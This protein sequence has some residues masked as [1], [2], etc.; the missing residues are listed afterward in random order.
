M[1]TTN[2]KGLTLVE[3]LVAVVLTILAAA[4]IYRGYVSIVSS[5]EVQEQ[6]IELQQ[7]L[8]VAMQTMVKEMRLA[9][10]DPTRK[11]G[12]SILNT[13]SAVNFD[14]TMDM[15]GNK[16]VD[17]TVNYRLNG[18]DLERQENGAGYE[19]IISNVEVLNFVYLNAN[20]A[21]L[22]LPLGNP[23]LVRTVQVAIVARTTNEDYLHADTDGYTNLQGTQILAPQ[24]DNY[25][26][27][28]FTAEVKCRNMGLM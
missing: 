4:G 28:V 6:L 14:F 22:G 3:L 7:S 24:N 11:S 12:A 19:A 27:R 15:D 5:N 25:H 1:F 20:G 8:R 21:P 23:G 9:G 2:E 16:I 17:T 18:N 10:Y 13:S 26:R